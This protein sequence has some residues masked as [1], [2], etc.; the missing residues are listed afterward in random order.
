MKNV[1]LSYD[2]S[3]R[4]LAEELRRI[5]LAQGYRPWIDRSEEAEETWH[6]EKDDA[7]RH[8]DALIILLTDEAAD[9]VHLTYE[10]AFAMGGNTPVFAI[11]YDDAPLHPSLLNIQRFDIRSFSDENHF[12]DYFVEEF[13][14]AVD[15]ARQEPAAEQPAAQAMPDVDRSVLPAEQGFW[16]VIRRG[17]IENAMFRLE[18]EVVTLGRDSANDIAIA[19]PQVSRFHLRLYR[20]GTDY[21]IED[22]DSTNGLRIAGKRVRG[23][24]PLHDG[25]GIVLGDSVALSYE[26][27]YQ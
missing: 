11:I 24:S 26:I 27:V 17:P 19:D 5:L 25:D 9:S 21:E 3:A 13:R 22:L 12:W 23:P 14:R 6:V 18:K 20:R 8:A 10:F 7:I 15:Q 4:D 16:I 2:P 1:Y